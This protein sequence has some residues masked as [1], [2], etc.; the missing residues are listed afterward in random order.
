MSERA[1]LKFRV[2]P[3]VFGLPVAE[4]AEVVP[5]VA[6]APATH[7]SPDLLGL[8]DLRGRIL[9]VFDLCRTLDLGERPL[10]LRMRI[11]VAEDAG[12]AI[13]L[14]A[15]EVLDVVTVPAASVR[16]ATAADP[17]AAGEVRAGGELWTVPS[18]RPFLDRA[19]AARRT[20]HP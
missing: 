3:A 13:G 15:D 4:V 7:P 6:F 18:L 12:E 1:F 9:P 17:F 2:G 16:A 11:V 8:I 20:H 19:P 5:I 14:L 10:T